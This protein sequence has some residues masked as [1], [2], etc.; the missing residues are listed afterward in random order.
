MTYY[1]LQKTVLFQ[2]PLIQSDITQARVS[3]SLDDAQPSFESI[4]RQLN[5]MR[6]C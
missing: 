5:I 1:R 3:K 6:N 2:L 4:E